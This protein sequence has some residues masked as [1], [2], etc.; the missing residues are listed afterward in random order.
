MLATY[1]TY[2]RCSQK[3]FR[4]SPGFLQVK[5]THNSSKILEIAS[6]N[7]DPGAFLHQNFLICQVKKIQKGEF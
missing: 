4:G 7:L 6:K 2:I 5:F 3:I 1:Y